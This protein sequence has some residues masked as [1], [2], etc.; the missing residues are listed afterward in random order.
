MALFAGILVRYLFLIWLVRF[1]VRK[2]TGK[3]G[4]QI[5][6][7]IVVGLIA[8]AVSS[9][10]GIDFNYDA[11]SWAVCIAMA[12]FVIRD[13]MKNFQ[14]KNISAE[15][16]TS[17]GK[18]SD[19]PPAPPPKANDLGDVVLNFMA[20]TKDY[21]I[22]RAGLTE[23]QADILMC[24]PTFGNE[25]DS[26]KWHWADLVSE[27]DEDPDVYLVGRQFD[28]PIMNGVNDILYRYGLDYNNRE[29][30]IL[31]YLKGIGH[32]LGN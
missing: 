24:D 1:L 8:Y 29:K 27:R 20:Y 9:S 2:G 22:Y 32:P 18:V 30:A 21:L 4:S 14:E 10:V 6:L 11:E 17:V 19:I 15:K 7:T 31:E 26:A 5:V 25:V 16:S 13:L 28:H 3:T 12:M 23:K